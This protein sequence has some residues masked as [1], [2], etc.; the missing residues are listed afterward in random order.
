MFEKYPPMLVCVF[1]GR[2]LCALNGE[3][4]KYKSNAIAYAWYIWKKGY[5]KEPIIKWI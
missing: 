5:T 1:S 3:F 2:T 4:D